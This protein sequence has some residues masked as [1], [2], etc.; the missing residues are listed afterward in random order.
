[1]PEKK[2]KV[3]ILT[4]RRPTVPWAVSKE[5]REAVFS[6]YSTLHKA[7]S[8]QHSALDP[9]AQ[10]H[11]VGHTGNQDHQSAGALFLQEMA[12]L[13]GLV[14]PGDSFLLKFNRKL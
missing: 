14:Q 9:P 10:G 3:I 2:K 4:I 1:M 5:V 8:V 13:V 12:K 7:P 11:G 6:L